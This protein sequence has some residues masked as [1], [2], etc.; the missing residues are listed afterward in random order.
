MPKAAVVFLVLQALAGFAVLL[1]FNRFAIGVG[2]SSLALIAIYPFMKRI[3]W[4]PQ[5]TLGL[6][7]SWG[8]LM[9]WAA[10]F[11]SLDMPALL[12][13]VGSI[14]WVAVGPRASHLP[15]SLGLNFVLGNSALG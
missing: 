13:Y 8:A 6:T 4:W 15:T 3:T 11:G 2:V 1:T 12:L 9:G 7:F 5:I 10:A 14:M